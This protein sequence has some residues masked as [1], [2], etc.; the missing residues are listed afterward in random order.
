MIILL[1]IRFFNLMTEPTLGMPKPTHW[2]QVIALPSKPCTLTKALT[3]LNFKDG[4]YKLLLSIFFILFLLFA[5]PISMLGNRYGTSRVLPVM[6]FCFG[7]FTFS[8]PPLTTLPVSSHFVGSSVWLN[9]HSYHSVFTMFY[10]GGELA[11][12]L[13]IFTPPQI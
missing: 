3:D 1:I 6:M 11:H 12:R 8:L 5:P 7:P 13:S 4:Q 9:P 10:R 2:K